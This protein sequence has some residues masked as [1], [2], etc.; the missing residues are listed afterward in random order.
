MPKFSDQ[1]A[2]QPVYH[3]KASST[4]I[5]YS[6]CLIVH[7]TPFI[8]V[9][10]R[11]VVIGITESIGEKEA[12]KKGYRIPSEGLALILKDYFNECGNQISFV[13]I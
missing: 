12:T 7:I 10:D 4:E 8:I 1:T 6:S 9:D 2:R 13:G 3:M 11:I 5:Q